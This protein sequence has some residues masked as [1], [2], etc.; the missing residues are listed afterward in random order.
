[1]TDPRIEKL[2]DVLV[3]YSCAVKSGEALLIEAIDI[4]HEFTK[5]LVRFEELVLDTPGAMR[6]LASWLGIDYD[7]RLATP[8]FNGYPVGP[9]SSFET[10]Q[11]GVVSAPVEPPASDDPVDAVPATGRFDL[12]RR[13][14]CGQDLDHGFGGWSGTARSESRPAAAAA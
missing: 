8:T 2:A 13:R 12:R 5:A 9:N 7:E 11:T 1:M 6:R 10:S 14:I 3:N 4:P